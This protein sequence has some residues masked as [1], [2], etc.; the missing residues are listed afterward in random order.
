MLNGIFNQLSVAINPYFVK[1]PYLYKGL[2]ILSL[3]N[4]YV[5]LKNSSDKAITILKR[6]G[7]HFL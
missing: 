3:F 4:S 6:M 1:T 7:D 2:S 5:H